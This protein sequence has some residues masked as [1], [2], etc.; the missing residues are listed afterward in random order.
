MRTILIWGGQNITSVGNCCQSQRK[1][2]FREVLLPAQSLCAFRQTWA[3]SY[4]HLSWDTGIWESISIFITLFFILTAYKQGK[5]C[6]TPA[7]WYSWFHTSSKRGQA[8]PWAN[9]G[10]EEYHSKQIF[11]NY[12]SY[13]VLLV[14]CV[15]C[16]WHLA[17][18]GLLLL[19][20]GI[21]SLV[22]EHWQLSMST[23]I[24]MAAATQ[25][26]VLLYCPPGYI[27]TFLSSSV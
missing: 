18:S 16:S 1:F 3:L 7:C 14:V 15:L 27:M 6:F 22:H 23:A 25:H 2:L 8:D 13:K 21:S 11:R 19:E 9:R 20:S 17:V 24:R 12:R 26:S 4:S 5:C 10:Q